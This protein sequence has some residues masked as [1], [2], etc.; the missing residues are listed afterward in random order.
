MLS[1]ERF[2]APGFRLILRSLV[3]SA[4]W[5][6]DVV[7]SLQDVKGG[8]FFQKSSKMGISINPLVPGVH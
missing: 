2:V 8:V 5:L 6:E 7:C 3:E 1:A 4:C